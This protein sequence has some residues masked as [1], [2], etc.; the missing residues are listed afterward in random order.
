MSLHQHPAFFRKSSA[1]PLRLWAQ[2]AMQMEPGLETGFVS[3]CCFPAWWKTPP[4][5]AL[6]AVRRRG[7]YKFMLQFFKA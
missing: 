2:H 3:C 1:A 4:E 5:A 7:T 6:M